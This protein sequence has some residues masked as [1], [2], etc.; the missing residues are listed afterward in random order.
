MR[1]RRRQRGVKED[2]GAGAEETQGRATAGDGGGSERGKQPDGRSL[3][4]QA[5]EGADAGTAG[6]ASP[7]D[8]PVTRD[9]WVGVL[10]RLHDFLRRHG[11]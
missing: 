8:A 10:G 6:P 5:A 4:T 9:E 1:R 3:Q 2:A 11:A 7:L